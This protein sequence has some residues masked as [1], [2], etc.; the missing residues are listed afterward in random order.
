MRNIITAYS[1]KSYAQ[2]FFSGSE[3]LTFSFRLIK[4]CALISVYVPGC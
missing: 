3:L 2:N 4:A 1:L